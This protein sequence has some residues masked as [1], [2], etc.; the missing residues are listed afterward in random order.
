MVL[1]VQVCFQ[2]CLT[3]SPE[4]KH[5]VGI[6]HADDQRFAAYARTSLADA[7]LPFKTGVF[8]KSKQR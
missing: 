2:N 5:K 4:H 8:A 6:Q 1:C 3:Y 7:A